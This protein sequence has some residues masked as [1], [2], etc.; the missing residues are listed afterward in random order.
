MERTIYERADGV[1]AARLSAPAASQRPIAALVLR[2][3]GSLR[4]AARGGGVR[5]GYW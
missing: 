5:A 1:S 3:A 4:G 2:G